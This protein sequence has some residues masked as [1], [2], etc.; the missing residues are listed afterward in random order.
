MEELLV[1]GNGDKPRQIQQR[2][3]KEPFLKLGRKV[4]KFA[5][6]N[7]GNQYKLEKSIGEGSYGQ[8]AQAV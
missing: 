1:T 2:P 4:D 6:W 5:D 7:V 8:V 3:K